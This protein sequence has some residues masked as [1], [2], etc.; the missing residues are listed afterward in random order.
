MRLLLES[1]TPAIIFKIRAVVLE[2]A[3]ILAHQSSVSLEVFLNFADW[4]G[5]VTPLIGLIRS[6]NSLHVPANSS[7][8]LQ[9]W[10]VLHV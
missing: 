6:S 8:F 4:G 10:M 7:N 2:S 1:S 5:F 3:R 9:S